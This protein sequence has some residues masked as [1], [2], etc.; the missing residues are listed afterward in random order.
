MTPPCSRSGKRVLVFPEGGRSRSGRVDLDAGPTLV[1]GGLVQRT[2]RLSRPVRLSARRTA[3][4]RVQPTLP[5]RGD[6]FRRRDGP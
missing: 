3:G 6:V 4:D 5:E 2:A 1:S